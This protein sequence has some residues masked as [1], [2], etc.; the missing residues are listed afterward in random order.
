MRVPADHYS[1]VLDHPKQ[2]RHLADH[3]THRRRVRQLRN[4]PDPIELQ[5]NQGLTLG[6]FAADRTSNLLHLD[7]LASLGFLAHEHSRNHSVTACSP[8]LSRRRA[9]S[10]ETLMLRRPATERGLSWCLR[11]SKVARTML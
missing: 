4:T 2:V 8:S 11:A 7:G 10:A 5:S 6:M 3:S 9:C 1:L